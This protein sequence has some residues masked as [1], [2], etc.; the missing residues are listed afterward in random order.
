MSKHKKGFTLVEL[1]AVIVVLAIILA[2]TVPAI[3]GVVRSSAMRAFESDAKLVLNAVKLK[4]LENP[5]LDP[6]TIT[7]ENINQS[8]GLTNENYADVK[9]EE[10]EG[11]RYIKITGQG[12]WAGL[13]A[14]GS[15]FDMRVNEGEC[16]N[17]FNDPV[18]TLLGSNPI[19]VQV[20]SA[21]SDA[22]ATATDVEDGDITDRIEITS[23]LNINTVGT[24]TITYN[25]SDNAGR[26][27]EPVSRTVNV[28]DTNNPVVTFSMNGNTT[29]AKNYSTDVTV[30]DA[31]GVNISK[32]LWTT[33]TTAPDE[34]TFITNFISGDTIST[35]VGVTGTYYLWVLAKDNQDNTTIIGSNAFNIDNTKPVIT[36]NG[37]STVTINVGEVYSDAGASATDNIDGSISVTVTGV[38]NPSIVGTYTIDYDAEDSSGNQADTVTR[39]INVVDVASPVITILGSNPVNINVG[40][41]YSDAGATALDDVDG[42]V[43]GSIVTTGTVNPNVAGT[44]TITYTVSDSSGN[45][46]IALR[47]VNVID[48]V[49][50][51]VAFSMN[52][53]TTWAKTRSTTV[54]VSDVGGVNLSSLKYQWTTSTS[55]PSES[56]FSTAFTNGGTINTPAGVTGT[57]YLWILAKDT[58]GNT[59][60][61]RTNAFNLDNTAPV[62][63]MLGSSPVNI[64]L[65]G[66]YTDAGATASDTHSGLAGNVTSTGTVNVGV[67]G[68]YTI[69]YNISDNAGNAAISVV[70]T[71][72]VK[73]PA[74]APVLAAGM[75][76]IKWNGSA[77]VD[78]T[79]S[80]SSWYSY[81]TTDKKWANARTADGSM[82]VWIPRYAYQIASGYHTSVA[83][84]I[85]V[86]FL[87][88][89]TNTADDGSTVATV[90]TY[91]GSSQTNY[92]KHPAFTFGT[93]ELPGIWVAKFE[94]SGTLSSLA[95]KPNVQCLLNQSTIGDVFTAIRNMETNSSYGWG[96]ASTLYASGMF[97]TDN[98]GVDT[99]L[100]KNIEWGAVVYLSKSSYGKTTEIWKNNSRYCTTGCAGN[101]SAEP[102]YY[103]CR[104]TYESTYGQYASTT[105]TIYG[106]YD[107]NGGGI[108]YVMGNYNNTRSYGG[109]N[110]GSIDDK[111]IDRYYSYNGSKFGDAVFETS[112]STSSA[113]SWYGDNSYMVTDTSPWFIRGGYFNIDTT[114]GAFNFEYDPGNTGGVVSFRATLLVKAGL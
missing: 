114:S 66:A 18:I 77:W 25:V 93:T 3:T 90:P 60:I 35:P 38:V 73:A 75:V 2:I 22:G 97:G 74:N 112:S 61:V 56:T 106:I 109:I 5:N 9:I 34:L 28:I 32:Y 30:S 19:D 39:T 67:A 71:I 50:P 65:G 76:P 46:A 14:C 107:I 82:W 63:T 85:N 100:M 58:S 102:G 92:I 10:N 95:S 48:N 62:I 83:G 12:K 101:S 11:I 16:Y 8:L 45:E 78:T 17:D 86:K 27:A 23:N 36:I 49:I 51:T 37:N 59:T 33:N 20:G 52:G 111:Y 91:S 113:S 41:T 80:D 24:Y 44:Y 54:T 55:T 21:Y 110:P 98:N 43:T 40:S 94:M 29:Y 79:T 69:T 99:H 26:E 88:G 7:Q 15:Y 4:L 103:G 84:T 42:N 68:T 87:Q 53:N 57:Y 81:T 72:Y 1:I 64:A 108:E 31:G 13:S 105:G 6:T 104:N 70:R 89:A 96:L 47:T